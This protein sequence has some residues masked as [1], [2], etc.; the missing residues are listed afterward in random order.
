MN[1]RLMTAAVVLLAGYLAFGDAL[2]ASMISTPESF[3]S[4]VGHSIGSVM[5][6][7]VTSVSGLLGS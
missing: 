2:H 1:L 3:A 6:G 7:I 5:S 4:D